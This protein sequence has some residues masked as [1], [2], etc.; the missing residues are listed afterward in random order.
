MNR[1]FNHQSLSHIWKV[2]R[3]NQDQLFV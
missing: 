1:D 2:M 3:G